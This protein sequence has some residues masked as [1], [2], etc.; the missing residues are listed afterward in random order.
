MFIGVEDI[1]DEKQSNK[2][3][4]GYKFF[5]FEV[6]SKEYFRI[7]KTSKQYYKVRSISCKCICGNIRELRKHEV[8]K[9][10][11]QSCGCRHK[12]IVSKMFRIGSI[13][14]EHGLKRCATCNQEKTADN[15]ADKKICVDK[16]RQTCYE[17]SKDYQLKKA[18]KI[19]LQDYNLILSNQGG[20]CGCCGSLD[21]KTPK[22]H[23]KKTHNYFVVDHCHK[24]GKVRGL[25]CFNCNT[26]IG[27][28]G[29]CVEGVR[30]AISYLEKHENGIDKENLT[31]YTEEVNN[32]KPCE[33]S[34]DCL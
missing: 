15:Y 32:T 11:R 13:L 33:K 17:C 31:D 23:F 7:T 34:D 3:P 30:Q 16:L 24:T 26:A 18:Y 19:S 21:S 28:L 9:K 25:L 2:Y 12:T 14:N 22:K 27:K 8:G 1:Q 29:D 20:G 6:I 5:D 4:I 10:H